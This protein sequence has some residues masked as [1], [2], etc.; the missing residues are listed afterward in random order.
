[1]RVAL[2]GPPQSGKTMLFSAITGQAVDAA[3]AVQEQN[4][5]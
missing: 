2:I 1:M 4:C 3:A 5:H